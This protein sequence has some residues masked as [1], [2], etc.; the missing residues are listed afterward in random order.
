MNDCELAMD[1]LSTSGLLRVYIDIDM[2]SDT[3][4]GRFRPTAIWSPLSKYEH[5]PYR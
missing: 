4:L 1:A 2:S 3:M 5:E